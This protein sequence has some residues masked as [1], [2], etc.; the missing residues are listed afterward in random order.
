MPTDFARVA[1]R[2]P[3][4]FVTVRTFRR[5]GFFDREQGGEQSRSIA[6]KRFMLPSAHWL[7]RSERGKFVNGS[8]QVE[9]LDENL[10][11]ESGG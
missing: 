11:V 6:A 4:V 2:I 7:T 3:D 10:T 1:S 5:A 8:P 9:F